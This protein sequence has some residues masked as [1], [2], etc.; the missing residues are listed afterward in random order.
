[1]GE[2]LLMLKGMDP[3]ASRCVQVWRV[4]IPAG[5]PKFLF[6]QKSEKKVGRDD[7]ERGKWDLVGSPLLFGFAFFSLL[8]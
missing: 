3:G 2:S 1:M 6:L 8:Y 5:E 7:E 4:S